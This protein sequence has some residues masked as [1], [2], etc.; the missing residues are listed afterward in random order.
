MILLT[1][2]KQKDLAAVS[3]QQLL[4]GQPN[5]PLQINRFELYEVNGDCTD[6]ELI[7]AIND[8]YI[9][10]NPNKH[11]LI[12]ERS[13]LLNENQLFFHVFRKKPLN[14]TSKVTQL[15]Q[16]LTSGH[17]DSIFMSEL[18]AFTYN[19]PPTLPQDIHQIIQAFIV[20]SPTNQAPF[21]H[22]LIH[23]VAALTFDELNQKLGAF[24]RSNRHDS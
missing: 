21:A 10:S 9:F 20:S 2:L 19:P 1:T 13:K 5:A 16:K 15:N 4:L 14:L 18:W 12:I 8:S 6:H 23:D 24:T 11:H 22:P 3:A 7:H 17:V